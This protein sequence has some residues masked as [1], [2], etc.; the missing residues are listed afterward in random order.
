MNELDFYEWYQ[1]ATAEEK[2]LV[3]R[4]SHFVSKF[5]DML[6]KPHTVIDPFIKIEINGMVGYDENPFLANFDETTYSY[7]V[8]PLDN[9]VAGYFS[10]DDKVLCVA[11][12]YLHMD[13]VIL[14]EMIH[15]IECHLEDFPKFYH[16]AVLICLYKHLRKEIQNLDDLILA[17]S[18][19]LRGEE[20]TARG[21]NHDILFLL[22][23]FD[24]DLKFGY[25][26]GTVCGYNRT[27]LF[28]TE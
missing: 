17:H 26:L 14:H 27:E 22:K 28:G 6:F 2:H 4:V 21:G 1:S 3:Q 9:D 20:I 25:K 5:D 12:E 19:L 23:S 15:M 16:D 8:K 10:K 18:H 13:S 7:I 24:L 11:P